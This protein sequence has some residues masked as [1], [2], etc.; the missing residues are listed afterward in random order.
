[1]LKKVMV[2]AIIATMVS[3][4]PARSEMTD[5]GQIRGTWYTLRVNNETKR[6]VGDAVFTNGLYMAMVY[7][8]QTD[9]W[10]FSLAHRS[11]KF[12]EGRTYD[13]SV[14][15]DGKLFTG[16]T[17]AIEEDQIGLPISKEF[18]RAFTAGSSLTIH[19]ASGTPLT[20]ISLAG[21]S[22]MVTAVARCNATM[23]AQQQPFGPPKAYSMPE[24]PFAP[25]ADGNAGR[26]FAG[27]E[28]AA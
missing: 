25:K 6:C 12:E 21:T 10:I 3:S 15:I 24:T 5:L 11:W 8:P 7:L 23:Q 9:T 2:A 16:E 28:R 18:L 1:M 27:P 17:E 13:G 14:S 19:H 22:K 20:T 4:A 26:R